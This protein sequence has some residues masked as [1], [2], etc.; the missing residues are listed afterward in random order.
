LG[1]G[2]RDAFGYQ[3][4]RLSGC[5]VA[6]GCQVAGRLGWYEEKVKIKNEGI[7]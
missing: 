3:I 2:C 1:A 4:A 6:F 5:K 7:V